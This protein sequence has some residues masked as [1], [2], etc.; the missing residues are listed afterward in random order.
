MALYKTHELFNLVLFFPSAA[1]L[2][3]EG[4]L[5]FTAGYFLS[6][7]VLSPDLDLPFSVPSK[8]LGV[9]RYLF[10]PFWVRHR[11][12]T[13][14]PLIGSLVKLGYL[15]FLFVFLYFV[16]VGALRLAGVERLPSFDPFEALKKL[17]ERPESFYF[18]LGVAVADAY[19]LLL[20]FIS[21]AFRSLRRR[22]RASSPE[23]SRS[24]RAARRRR[25]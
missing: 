2:P 10:I 15:V 17:A 25:A 20:D 13:H 24:S 3:E 5:P 6:T 4:R 9:F 18:V 23:R 12:V 7:F 8:R 11:G 19:H 1:L 16:L 22:R 14:V 21:S